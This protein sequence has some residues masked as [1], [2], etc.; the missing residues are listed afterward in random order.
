MVLGLVVQALAPEL[1]LDGLLQQFRGGKVAF[2]DRLVQLV[3]KVHLHPWHTPNYT[4]S[5]T[6]TAFWAD[7]D[8]GPSFGSLAGFATR[9]MSEPRGTLDYVSEPVVVVPYQAEWPILFAELAHRLRKELRDVAL[10]IDHIGSTSV[11][12][13]DAKPIIDIQV[14]VASFEPLDA[15][16]LP[17]ERVGFFHRSGAE[18]TKRY[19]R[20]RPGDRRTHIHVRR[21]GSFNEQFALLFRDFLRAHPSSAAAYARLKYDLAAKFSTAEQRHGYVM[22]KV[23]FVWKTT[24]L[25]DE[26]AG[27]MGW[28]PG[29]PDA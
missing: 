29:P 15:F 9:R 17:L 27:E 10:R 23:P 25:A 16:R 21:A 18:L 5:L 12:G 26:W 13:L 8:N 14:S 28:E 7:P 22:A 4:H 19:F 20:E 11:L 1:R 3:R 2:L 6:C 24:Q